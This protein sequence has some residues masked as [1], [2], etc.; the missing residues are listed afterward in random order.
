MSQPQVSVLLL[1][2]NG[3]DTLP[4]VLDGI[5]RQQVPFRVETIVVDS[6]STD[7][8]LA[9]LERRVDRLLRIPPET[10]NHGLTRN[11]GI[12]ACRGELVVL[13]VQ[14]AVPGSDLWLAKLVEPLLADA[15]LAGSYARQV[16]RPNASAVTRHYLA[17]WAGCSAHPRTSAL[18]GLEEFQALTPT[19][20][21]LRCTFDNVCSCIRRGVWSDHPFPKA[22]IAEDVEW[23]RDVLLAGY[24]LAYVPEAT[25]IHSH[26]RSARYELWRTYLVHRKL[27]TLFSLRTVPTP[28][29]LLRAVAISLGVHV[30]CLARDGMTTLGR[31]REIVRALALAFAFPL[32]QYL[33]RL[34]ADTGWNLL[35]PRG[36]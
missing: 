21:L 18:S 5:A 30:R 8:T 29:H 15:S 35:R 24:R 26:D 12:A 20:R 27:R 36:V 4:A 11:L 23:A 7:A 3:E 32:G 9:L 34:S 1:T 6:G 14:D 17:G 28:F 25:V 22:D 19:E 13:L 16:P 31:P 10:F 33:G 2:L